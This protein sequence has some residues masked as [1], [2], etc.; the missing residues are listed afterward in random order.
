MK[1]QQ[2]NKVEVENEAGQKSNKPMKLT[3]NN[4]KAA[5][6]T[7]TSLNEEELGENQ[8]IIALKKENKYLESLLKILDW[9]RSEVQ[10]IQNQT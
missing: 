1:T 2:I 3:K 5:P 4:D 6:N 8:Y 9:N 10:R 7:R